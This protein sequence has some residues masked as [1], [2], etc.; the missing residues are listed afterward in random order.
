MNKW[1]SLKEISSFSLKMDRSTEKGS[2]YSLK[3]TLKIVSPVER[4]Y[5]DTSQK[6]TVF[7]ISLLLKTAVVW[8][9]VPWRSLKRCMSMLVF[10]CSAFL[11]IYLVPTFTFMLNSFHCC[12]LQIIKLLPKTYTTIWNYELPNQKKVAL[13]YQNYSSNLFCVLFFCP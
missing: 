13:I 5:C 11:R 6:I 10:L 9:K 3:K 4:R 7:I 8:L 2:A 1:E 12:R